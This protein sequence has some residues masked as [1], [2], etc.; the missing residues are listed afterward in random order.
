MDLTGEVLGRSCFTGSAFLGDMA[1]G[2]DAGLM[3]LC[4]DAGLAWGL[5]LAVDLDWGL[6]LEAGLVGFGLEA[7][8]GGL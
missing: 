6:G 2:F 1:T 8:L 5:G 4:F 7:G 3:G